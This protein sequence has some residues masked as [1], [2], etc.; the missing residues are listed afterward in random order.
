MKFPFIK[1]IASTDKIIKKHLNP[2][3]I[4]SNKTSS[5]SHFLTTKKDSATQSYTLN[6]LD[7]S[8]SNN[9]PNGVFNKNFTDSKF[10]PN[11]II[12]KKNSIKKSIVNSKNKKRSFKALFPKNIIIQIETLKKIND[13]KTLYGLYQLRIQI[14]NFTLA[15]LSLLSIYCSI[16][17]N[18]YFIKKSFI[19]LEKKYNFK[20]EE[21]LKKENK[22]EISYFY[23][24]IEKRKISTVENI[25][26]CINLI[27][28]IISCIIITFKYYYNIGLLKMDKKIS[29][30]NNFFSSG[31]FHYFIIECIINLI[32]YPPKINKVFELSSHT[33]RYLYTLNSFFL[34]LSFLKMYNIFRIFFMASKYSSK[35][36][37]AICQTY[38]TNYNLLFIIRAE[39]NSRPLF[40][41]IMIFLIFI[42]ITSLLLRSFE[43]FGYDIIK[44][45]YGR[46]GNNDLRKSIN[47]FWLNIISITN[48]GFGDEFPRTNLGRIIIFM[49]SLFGMFFLGFLIANISGSSQFNAKEGRAYL[50]MKKILSKEN[51]YHK[52]AEVIKGILFLRRNTIN[53]KNKLG[54]KITLIKESMVLHVKFNN[55][56]MNFNDELYV[57][58][59]YSIPIV[60]LI[61]NMENKLYDNVKNLSILLNKIEDINKDLM[62]LERGQNNLLETLKKI[63]LQQSK[64]TKY[65]LEKHNNNFL[66]KEQIFKD[67]DEEKEKKE[68]KE[69]KHMKKIDLFTLSVMN[70]PVSSY[71]KKEN[72]LLDFNRINPKKLFGNKKKNESPSI[73]MKKTIK[74]KS[75]LKL[76]LESNAIKSLNVFEKRELIR[77]KLNN[78]ALKKIFKNYK[79]DYIKTIQ[80]KKVNTFKEKKNKNLNNFIRL[81]YNDANY[82]SV[83]K[84]D[85]KH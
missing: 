33:V 39:M 20:I 46:K 9:S 49:T 45:Y 85:I 66:K 58:R 3:D 67:E 34:I 23:K 11:N 40:F 41:F 10:K 29:E 60:N 56:L 16:M 31:I 72:T 22:E 70:T 69:S 64:I 68:E 12:L 4:V 36:S 7:I 65:L 6:T 14:C 52:S 79:F 19:F 43:V 13:F 75:K 62:K 48:I 24:L 50:K 30:Y 25:F 74:I 42:F 55:D 83:R 71:S 54:D 5:L 44:G 82:E 73:N 2:N 57:A 38:K 80:I 17:D 51:I 61:K 21:I 35:I 59:F 26:R 78:L 77:L 47:N 28:S 76:K 1:G 84:R 32:S 18:E 27:S 37:E 53:I 81:N 8:Q 15:L 63:N